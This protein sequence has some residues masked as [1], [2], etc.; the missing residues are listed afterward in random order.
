MGRLLR[1]RSYVLAVL[2]AT[3]T[4]VSLMGVQ[5]WLPSFLMR[6]HD[7]PPQEVGAYLGLIR[8]PAGVAGA[9][10]G[11]LLTTWLARRDSRWLVW[12]PALFMALIFVS[13]MVML[14][15]SSGIAWKI[16]MAAD[17]FFGSGQVGPIFAILLATADAR[18]RAVATAVAMLALHIVGFTI[19]PLAIG[20]L[21]DVLAPTL[22]PE[23]IRTSITIVA[24][25]A[26][27]GTLCCLAIGRLEQPE[28]A[29]A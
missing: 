2:A 6:V 5:T 29:R 18:S 24:F 12:T 16:G 27:A 15:S 26:I 28:P 4:G 14:Y 10:F 9:L 23:A 19:G 3:L 17:T 8:G 20:I 11:G 21:N 1:T 13:D 22:G 7:L 25:S